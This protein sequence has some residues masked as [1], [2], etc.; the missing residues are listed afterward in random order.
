MF[1]APR[2]FNTL[3][4]NT[5][6]TYLAHRYNLRGVGLHHL[7]QLKPPYLL[8]PNHVNFWDPFLVSVFIKRPI[9]FV[10]ADGNFRS[11][12]MRRLLS[13]VGAIPKAKAKSDTATVRSMV[14]LLKRGE[15]VGIFA[16]GQRTW[17]GESLTPMAP[18]AKLLR[19]LKATV[20][21]PHLRGAYLSLP[22]WSPFRRK[23]QLE[24][25]FEETRILRREEL[26]KLSLEEIDRW[27]RDALTY[28]ETDWEQERRIAFA[29]SR[30]AE[31]AETLL[32]LCPGCGYF[33]T[34]ESRG[35]EI[36]C[37]RCGASATINRFGE[38]R[39]GP[40]TSKSIPFEQLRDWNRWQQQELRETV[41]SW[42]EGSSPAAAERGLEA[43]VG[44]FTVRTGRGARPLRYRGAVNLALSR[45]GLELRRVT[46]GES[47]PGDAE[48][49]RRIPFAEI[50][51]LHVQLRQDLEFY[52]R[53]RLH[54]L[55]PQ[56]DRVSSHFWERLLTE[57][58]NHR[59]TP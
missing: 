43:E 31:Y 53:R 8:I 4:R 11:S 34:L 48:L 17:D 3:L 2:W 14:E 21:V 25:A 5:V 6:G 51:A 10:A 41:K 52:Y 30:S 1:V 42:L 37:K 45:H 26:L 38:L 46:G 28:S 40:T 32:Y 7:A 57:I 27:L 56:S 16:E 9:Y 33:H 55:R 47:T 59:F 22:R 39:P 35:K 58:R 50:E 13:L 20:V 29:S 18:T 24:L 19:F 12:L 49:P 15:V 36:R 23:G 44:P 54:V